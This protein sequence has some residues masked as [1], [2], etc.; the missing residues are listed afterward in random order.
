M[1]AEQSISFSLV[2]YTT[3]CEAYELELFNISYSPQAPSLITKGAK[4]RKYNS[5]IYSLP[6]N[7]CQHAIGENILPMTTFTFTTLAS[8]RFDATCQMESWFGSFK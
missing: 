1:Q 5:Q 2:L 6:P 4:G 8:T 7:G 3:M